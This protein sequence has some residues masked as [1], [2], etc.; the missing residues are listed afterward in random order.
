M[1]LKINFLVQE[2]LL[3]NYQIRESR[4][5]IRLS[6]ISMMQMKWLKFNDPFCQDSFRVLDQ[7]IKNV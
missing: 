4:S 5:I 3:S 7:D 2:I 6:T 1:Y